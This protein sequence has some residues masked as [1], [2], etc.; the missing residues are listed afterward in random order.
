MC[1]Y[2][3]MDGVEGLHQRHGANSSPMALGKGLSIRRGSTV[4]R[5]EQILQE[6]PQILIYPS[7]KVNLLV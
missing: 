4:D 6:A 2:G 1:K 3:Q 7:S 5:P